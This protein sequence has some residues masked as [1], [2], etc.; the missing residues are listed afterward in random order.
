MTDEGPALL[1]EARRQLA[2]CGA[3]RYCE[4][5]CAVFPALER[6]PILLAGDVAQLAN[7][8]HDCRACY[9]ACMYAPPHEFGVDV[10]A[11]LARARLDSYE[12]FAW[13]RRL[14]WTFRHPRAAVAAASAAGLAIAGAAALA[15]GGLLGSH[16][17]PGAFY[18][19]VPYLAILV[20]ALV[21][22]AFV[23]AVMAAA[24]GRS[25]RAAG[26]RPG[27]LLDGRL[28]LTATVEALTLRWLGG[29]G[30]GCHYPDRERPS[31]ARRV[32]HVLLV[33]GLLLAFA[34][35]VTAAVLQ[36]VLGRLPPYPVLSVPVVL[37]T[38][39]GAAVIAGC[40]GLLVLK[41]AAGDDL[42]PAASRSL[43]RAL[44]AALELVAVTGMLT[45]ALR[46][47]PALGVALVLHLGSLV[48]LYVTAPYGK[49]VHGVHRFAAL[50]RDAA[51][52]RAETGP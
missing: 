39:G 8:C 37:G 47:T 44:L 29:G 18:A 22:S 25:W 4:G 9:Q 45:L 11:L 3:C 1:A 33:G 36:D 15:G 12:R 42:A 51:E 34:A 2:V 17:G 13:P 35:T 7:L 31:S 46:A 41:P 19:V 43:D 20:P 32:L 52:R 16:L 28:W 30:G 14:G 6:R 38:L 24:F 10:P 48:A 27:E 40:T 49:L 50:L 23:A 21:V 26:G 5:Y